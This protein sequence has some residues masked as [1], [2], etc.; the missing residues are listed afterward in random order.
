M[1][2]RRKV[3]HILNTGSYSGAENVV[4][5]II[6]NMSENVDSVYLSKEGSIREILE[7]RNISFYP[8]NKL[9]IKELKKAVEEIKPD[10]IH[11]HDFT[12]G[13]MSAISIW[14]VPIINHLHNN[15]PWI[16]SVGVK[17]IVY[18]ISTLRY[19]RILSVSES[20]MNEFV[21][22]AICKH[23]SKVVGN[24]I[25]VKKIKNSIKNKN[26]CEPYDIA[27][28][29]RFSVEKNPIFFL[30]IIYELKKIIPNI[31][32]KMIGDGELR[33]QIENKI[34]KLALKE[35]VELLGF[36]SNPYEY[37]YQAK[38]LCMPSLWEGFGLAAVEAFALG[39]PVVASPVGGLVNIVNDSCGRLC[40]TRDAYVEEITRLLKDEIYY[41]AKSIKSFDKSRA[42][43]NTSSYLNAIYDAYQVTN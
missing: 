7:D 13:I 11:A 37:L 18:A 34:D 20:V 6:S 31:K 2:K 40:E 14:K 19:A 9:A 23:K 5:S 10:I 16:K 26:V 4:I 39:K 17:S 30:E 42:L 25:D 28:L 29:G 32:A 24:P 15:S 27:F 22:S 43:D 8:V 12:A 38:I 35:N 33:K 36:Q 41:R 3:L 21:F 1:K